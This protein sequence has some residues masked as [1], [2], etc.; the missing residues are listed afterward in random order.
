MRFK[1]ASRIV[2]LENSNRHSPYF[3]AVN[4][5]FNLVSVQFKTKKILPYLQFVRCCFYG[6]KVEVSVSKNLLKI[7]PSD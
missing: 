1:N 2:L 4:P 7:S 5:Y 3:T 6:W